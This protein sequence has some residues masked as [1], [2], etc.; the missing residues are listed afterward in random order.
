[1]P[2]GQKVDKESFWNK[3]GQGFNKIAPDLLDTL[4]LAGNMINN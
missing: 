1:M 2:V 3:L 4:R